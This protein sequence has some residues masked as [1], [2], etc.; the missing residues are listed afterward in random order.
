MRLKK[1]SEALNQFLNGIKRSNFNTREFNSR[2][3][4]RFFYVNRLTIFGHKIAHLF[5]KLLVVKRDLISTK[6]GQQLRFE[7]KN[8]IINQFTTIVF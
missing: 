2:E 3:L 5:L 1:S 7:F 6:E 4:V 8:K